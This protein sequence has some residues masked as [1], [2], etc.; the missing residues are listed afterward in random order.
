MLMLTMLNLIIISVLAT[1][2]TINIMKIRYG[3][4]CA[5]KFQVN[6]IW[7]KININ[8]INITLYPAGHILGSA[9]ILLENKKNKVL[10]TGDYKTVSDDTA[11]SFELV[12]TE[13]L[14]TEATF[15]LP[16]FKHPNPERK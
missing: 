3:E 14:I 7:K 4:N 6:R 10:I 8:G 16:I 5:K 1:K 15:G 2:D 9:Q 11:Q 13:T 12:K